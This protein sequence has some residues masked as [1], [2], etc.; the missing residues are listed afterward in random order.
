ML[1]V[2]NP[3]VITCKTQLLRSLFHDLMQRR[4][5]KLDATVV[6]DALTAPVS[7]RLEDDRSDMH[8]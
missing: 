8:L 3:G 2:A 6:E 5:P 1:D 4:L 7:Q